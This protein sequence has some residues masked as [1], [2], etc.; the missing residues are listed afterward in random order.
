MEKPGLLPNHLKPQRTQSQE[1]RNWSLPVSTKL[2]VR[3]ERSLQLWKASLCRAAS[4]GLPE[5][6]QVEGGDVN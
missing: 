6:L 4:G 1:G 2:G 3:A 5:L